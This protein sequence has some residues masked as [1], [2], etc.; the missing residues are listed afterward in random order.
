MNEDDDLK[1]IEAVPIGMEVPAA[2]V[3][4]PVKE[5]SPLPPQ[6]SFDW[7]RAHPFN[8]PDSVWGTPASL[9][10][11]R[12]LLFTKKLIEDAKLQYFTTAV[13][14]ASKKVG[15]SYSVTTSWMEKHIADSLPWGT[16]PAHFDAL[17]DVMGQWSLA[18][19]N[20]DPVDA[21]THAM[22]LYG[23][24]STSTTNNT[25]WTKE[26]I[27]AASKEAAVKMESLRRMQE[28]RKAQWANDDLTRRVMSYDVPFSF[29]RQEFPSLFEAPQ[30]SPM[31]PHIYN[32]RILIDP[33]W[34]VDDVE[35]GGSLVRYRDLVRQGVI[36]DTPFQRHLHRIGACRQ[37]RRWAAGMTSTETWNKCVN[38][39]WMI[40][41]AERTN[42]NLDVSGGRNIIHYMRDKYIASSWSRTP[43]RDRRSCDELRAGRLQQ[44]WIEP[45]MGPDA[46]PPEDDL[47]E[48]QAVITTPV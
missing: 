33:L 7:A 1:E 29:Y 22:K 5:A 3:Q 8:V 10:V 36:P 42:V 12:D 40:F 21:S 6:I 46:V 47:K 35:Y 15:D 20:D 28:L 2:V 19:P 25:A 48:V 44:P 24:T 23:Y 13:D 18:G 31:E 4:E 43:E 39:D 9:K 30:Y 45:N 17:S 38:P 32:R 11:Y 14:P 16:H 27:L 41:W 37:S 26:D 34:D